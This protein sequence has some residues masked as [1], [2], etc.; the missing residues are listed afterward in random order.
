MNSLLLMNDY[1]SLKKKN[2]KKKVE[3]HSK[4][5]VVFSEKAKMSK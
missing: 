5:A 1:V 2:K 4:T 3:L